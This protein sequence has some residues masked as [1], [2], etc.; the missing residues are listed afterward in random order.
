[1][2]G[3]SY[4]YKWTH[5]PTLN[6]YVGVRSSK[7]AHINDG[8][9]CSSK[10]VK[11]LI[12]DNSNDWVRTIIDV[13]TP[14]EMLLLEQ[15]ILCLFDAKNDIRSFNKHN[16]D[17]K[18]TNTG[19]SWNGKR[20]GINNPNYGKKCSEETK[21]K[22]R[23]KALGRPRL[24]LIGKKRPDHAEK[25]RELYTGRKLSEETKLKISKAHLGKKHVRL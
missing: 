13:G 7:K 15:E 19:N 12:S 1:M 10:I 21:Q 18:F 14:E 9:I 8:Y 23:E 24:D 4:V 16:S 11:K 20:S 22:L 2:I 3:Q 17:M 5:V 25:M 6:W